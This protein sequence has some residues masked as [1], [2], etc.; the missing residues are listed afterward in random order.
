MSTGMRIRHNRFGEG[1]IMHIDTSGA[2][3]KM[4]VNFSNADQR[5]LLL[6]FAKFEI[7]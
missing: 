5:T 4:T 3:P 2:D 6:K 7:L 1:I